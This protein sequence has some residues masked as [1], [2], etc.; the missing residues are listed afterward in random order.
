[1]LGYIV[2]G[3]FI[4]GIVLLHGSVLKAN[5]TTVALSFLLGVLAISA[6]WGLRHAVVTSIAAALA[7]NYFFLIPVGTFTIADPQ[8]WVALGAFLVTA[9][10]ASQLSER[11]R[12]EA[13]NA[14]AR[15]QEVERLYGF[16]Q[17]LLSSDNLAEVLNR[18]PKY[19]VES[20]NVKSAAILLS[21]RPDVYRSGAEE[22]GLHLPD[23]HLTCVRGEPKFDFQSK[24]AFMPLKMGMR[25]VGS[26]GVSGAIPSRQTLD[27]LS[28]LIAIA[29]ER[30]GTVEK[31]A[32]AEIARESEQLRSALLDSLTHEFRTPLTA[33][34]ASVTSL[35]GDNPID[36]SQRRELLTVIN[37][38]SDR[39]NRLVGEAAEMA[40]LDAHSVQLNLHSHAMREAVEDA[41]EQ[42]KQAL[43]HHPVKVDLPDDLPSVRMDLARIQEVV[44]QLLEN[45]AKYSPEES[46]IHITAEARNQMLTTS[47]ADHGPGIDDFEQGLIFEKFYR[48]RNQRLQIQGTGMGLAI[49]KA[50]V[51]AH[52]GTVGVTSQLG[53]GSVFY[54][55]LPIT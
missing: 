47:V 5:P 37:E 39:L 43:R 20:F 26:F 29:I 21:N 14:N 36:D 4:C 22:D 54:F 45:A 41:L 30:A 27:A 35:L 18:I 40:Q 19:V 11:A 33:V 42:S 7:F 12:R 48:G 38:E 17:Q 9:V 32:R 25:V 23:L 52:G 49:V 46:P 55:S 16:S 15:R 24:R 1:M 31:L 8:N 6:V 51:E 44:M 53:N 2:A 13:V 10:V 50:I 28:S 34:K 3:S